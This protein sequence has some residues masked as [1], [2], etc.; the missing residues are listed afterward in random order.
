MVNFDSIS[1]DDSVAIIGAGWVGLALV[2]RFNEE[3]G[4]VMATSTSSE[5]V[6]KLRR[7]GIEAHHLQLPDIDSNHPILTCQHI[8]ICIVPGIRY[9]QDDY[10]EK[11]KSLVKA[12][13]QRNI[14]SVT[15]LSSTAVYNGLSGMVNED[16]TLALMND[17]TKILHNAEKMILESTLL[18]KTVLRLGGLIGYD[19]QPGRFFKN[20]RAIP[21]PESVINFVHRDDVVGV[22]LALYRRYLSLPFLTAKVFNVVAP[23]H[24]KRRDF[25]Q[26]ALDV[27]ELGGANFSEQTEPIGKKVDCRY[28]NELSFKFKYPDIMS[29]LAESKVNKIK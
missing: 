9:G 7:L 8:I 12:A 25:Y 17:K 5:G 29:Y 11:I 28:L 10:P 20:G 14:K 4:R 27:L 6:E 18:N 2:K 21:N 22:I 26:L 19:R 13:E 23:L 16:S 1:L 3:G 24:P 15:L